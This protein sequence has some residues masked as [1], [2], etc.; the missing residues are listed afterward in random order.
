MSILGFYETPKFLN[1]SNEVVDFADFLSNGTERITKA[2]RTISTNHGYIH[3]G[4]GFTIS[5]KMDIAGNKVG[6]FSFTGIPAGTFIHFQ[7]ALITGIGGPIY[8]SLLEDYT[9][10]GGTTLTPINRNRNSTNASA[11]TLKGSTDLTAVAGTS[12]LSLEMLV[13]PTTTQGAQKLGGTGASGAEEW[14]WKPEVNYVLAFANSTGSQV[15]VGYTL[16]WYEEAM[17]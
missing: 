15:T 9:F 17:A 4:I 14:I 3:E 8:V 5:N 16:F 2:Y 6:G 13:L 1:T 12:A 7:P 10:T 11:I